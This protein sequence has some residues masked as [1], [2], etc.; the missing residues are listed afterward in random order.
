MT[1]IPKHDGDCSEDT[2]DGIT[3]EVVEEEHTHEGQK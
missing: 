1:N 2:Y 3:F